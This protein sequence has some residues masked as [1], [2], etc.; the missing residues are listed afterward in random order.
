MPPAFVKSYS[1]K[2]NKSWNRYDRCDFTELLYSN[3]ELISSEGGVNVSFL[4]NDSVTEF[5]VRVQSISNDG[6]LG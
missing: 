2:R 4:L 3:S 6:V 1:H 5:M